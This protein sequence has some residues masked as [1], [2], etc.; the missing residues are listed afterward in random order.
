MHVDDDSL[1]SIGIMGVLVLHWNELVLAFKKWKFIDYLGTDILAVLYKF[2][3][4]GE[5]V[6]AG[7][8]NLVPFLA[9]FALKDALFLFAEIPFDCIFGHASPVGSCSPSTVFES[10]PALCNPAILHCSFVVLVC[11]PVSLIKSNLL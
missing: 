6:L 1:H 11:V 7:A 4:D 10:R 2:L 5:R 8:P 9:S 3:M